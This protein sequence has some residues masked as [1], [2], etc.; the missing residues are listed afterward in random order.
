MSNQKTTTKN[1][2]IQMTLF[3]ELNE[4]SLCQAFLGTVMAP[5]F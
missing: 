3:P 2:T 5:I 4:T 1:D